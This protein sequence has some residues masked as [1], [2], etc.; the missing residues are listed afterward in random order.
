MASDHQP[1]RLTLVAEA[2][3]DHLDVTRHG[4]DVAVS[5]VHFDS[6]AITP[7][8]LYVAI[9]GARADGHDFIESALDRG[10]VAVVVEERPRQN[11]PFLLVGDSRAALGWAAAAVQRWPARELHVVGITGTNGK[12]TVAHMLAAMAPATGREMAVI[13]TVSANLDDLDVSPRTTPESSD[14]QR[15]FRS[16]LDRGRITD[17]AMEVSSHAMELGRVNGTEFDLVAFTNLSQDHLDY[18]HTMEQ[19]Y[20]AK[21]KLFAR[22]WAPQAVIWT[23]NAW[24]KRLSEE[25]ALPIITVGTEDTC[26]VTVHLGRETPEHTE[27][28]LDIAARTV[29]V[30]IAL[31]GRFNVANAAVALTCARLQGWD[32]DGSVARLAAMPPVPGRY[33]TI[34]NDRGIWVVVDYAHTPDAI[35]SVIAETRN[36]IKG[37]V[38][39]IVGAGGDRDREKRPLMGRALTVADVAV[40]TTDNPRSENPKDIE[41]QMLSGVPAGIDVT[42]EPDRRLAIKGA[43]EQAVPGDAVLILGKG[44]ETG[45]EFADRTLPFDDSA[46]AR[47]ELARLEG[48]AT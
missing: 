40:V 11:V 13:G 21:A 31:A 1:V 4:D 26:D 30:I 23:D 18:H 45:Q 5:D 41:A 35:A 17:V 34:P 8:S 28:S 29:D 37:R 10:A 39:A 14:L 48:D 46:V 12:T 16:L 7:G 22:R 20:A 38:I 27:F 3:G 43:L 24:G 32:L 47:E 36:L 25:T 15:I 33:N 19:Y 42:V 2:I 44:H 9:R 6:R